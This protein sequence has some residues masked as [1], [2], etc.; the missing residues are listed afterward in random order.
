MDRKTGATKWEDRFGPVIFGQ[1]RDVSI[2]DG[3]AFVA[4]FVFTPGRGYGFVVR[5]YDLDSGILLWSQEVN[6]GAQCAEERPGFARCVA[7]ALAVHNGR[8]FAVGHLTR[9]AARSDFAVL[10]FDAATGTP[11]WESVT[12]SSGTSA[13]DYAWA[14][15]AKGDSVFVLG[16]I[17][18]F[19]G[20]LLQSH[21]AKTGAIRWQQQVPGATNFT[22]ENT[23]AA[24]RHSVFIAGM[25][26]QSRFMVQAYDA[27]TGAL[28][29]D[30]RVDDMAG[31]ASALTLGG[32]EEDF[33]GDEEDSDGRL[34]ATGIVGCDPDTFLECELAVRAYDPRGGLIWQRADQARGGDW[35]FLTKPAAGTGQLFVG[36]RELL[37]DGQYHSTVFSYA[38]Q[39]GTPIAA[40]PFDQGS[41]SPVGSVGAVSVLHG[42]LFVAGGR[43]RSFGGFDFDFVLQSYRTR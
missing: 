17:G 2:E 16:E 4:G 9:T 42:R 8:V 23:L 27:E 5:A 30:D 10:A 18:N 15:S 39:G 11:L 40:V 38:A 14:V 6:R 1:A 26:A 35:V 22:L 12:D 19:S 7:K 32:G 31:I 20:L 3:R 29:W 13:N 41:A 33:E 37:E 24:D 43:E 36:A 34:F 28:Q 21:D 25:D